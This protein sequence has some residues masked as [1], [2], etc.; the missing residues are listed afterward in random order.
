MSSV[1]QCFAKEGKD[2][3]RDESEA[4]AITSSIFAISNKCIVDAIRRWNSYRSHSAVYFPMDERRAI[5][6]EEKI[7]QDYKYARRHK[8][9]PLTVS[10]VMNTA[11]DLLVR[12]RRTALKNLSMRYGYRIRDKKRERIS[13]CKFKSN[14]KTSYIIY[15]HYNA[16][17]KIIDY[18]RRSD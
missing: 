17:I 14:A 2:M 8:M 11:R 12:Y 13:S 3:K 18:N 10:N 7:V 5:F 1:C 6:D 15:Q 16:I 9:R 4:D